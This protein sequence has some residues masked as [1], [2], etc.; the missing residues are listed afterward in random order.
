MRKL[1]TVTIFSGILTVVRMA[2]G[3]L[4]AKVVAIYTGPSGMAM[5]GQVQSLVAALS[6][7]AASPG[8]NGLVRYTAEY[9]EQGLDACAPWWSA[10]LKWGLGL[11]VPIALLAA[12]AADPISELL[13]DRKDYAW[14]VL[15]ISLG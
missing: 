4:I 7:I 8:G 3:M 11:L 14:L 12:L 15:L 6:G 5:L 2:S 1:L 9:R 10:S 13:F